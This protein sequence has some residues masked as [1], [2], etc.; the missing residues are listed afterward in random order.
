MRISSI[1]L[2]KLMAPRLRV[3]TIQKVTTMQAANSISYYLMMARMIWAAPVAFAALATGSD[4]IAEQLGRLA[5][6]AK[7]AVEKLHRH[8]DFDSMTPAQ[9]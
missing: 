7:C 8:D 9:A 3:T 1:F 2:C 4:E 6:R 5:E